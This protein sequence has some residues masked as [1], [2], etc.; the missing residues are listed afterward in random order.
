MTD[1]STV[2]GRN[3][4]DHDNI[5]TQE[6]LPGEHLPQTLKTPPLCDWS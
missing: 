5:E 6:S 1:S 2:I 3:L 4:K